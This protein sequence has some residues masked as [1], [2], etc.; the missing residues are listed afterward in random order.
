MI[1]KIMV[2]YVVALNLNI[3]EQAMSKYNIIRISN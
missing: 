1:K 2:K 3:C